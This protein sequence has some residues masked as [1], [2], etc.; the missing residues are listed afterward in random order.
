MPRRVQCAAPGCTAHVDAARKTGLCAV[1]YNATLRA[2]PIERQPPRWPVRQVQVA[3][4]YS[5]G[6]D[7]FRFNAISL[8]LEPWLHGGGR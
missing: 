2:A 6:T 8:P 4:A 1:H 5:H 3:Q 7:G